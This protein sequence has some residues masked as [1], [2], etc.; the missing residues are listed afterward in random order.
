MKSLI[1]QPSHVRG[2]GNILDNEDNIQGLHCRVEAQESL[3]EFNDLELKTYHMCTGN[4]LNIR[5]ILDTLSI[6]PSGT[7][8]IDVRVTDNENNPVS[9]VDLYVYEEEELLSQLES[10]PLSF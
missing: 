7:V 4:Q 2:L 9:G 10:V 1:I 8:H 6:L 3:V 5:F